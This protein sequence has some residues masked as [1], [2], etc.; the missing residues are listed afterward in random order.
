MGALACAA[1][2]GLVPAAPPPAPRLRVGIIGHTGRGDYGHGLHTLWLQLPETEI[3]AVADPDAAGL[4]AALSKLRCDRGFADY[5]KMLS[6]VR[7]D[8]V[9]IG[10]RHIDQHRDAALAAAEA[11]VRGLYIE[12]PFCR[13][14]AEADEIVAA[15]D[16]H[17]VKVAIA[18]RNRYHP[19]L[20]TIRRLLDDGAVGR[21]LEIRARGKE[22]ARGGPLDLWVL[23]SH[24]LNIVHCLGGRPRACTAMVYQDARPVTAADLKPGAEGVGPIAGNRLHARF[25]I[26]SGAPAFFDSVQNAGSAAAG[27]G[28]QWIGTQ[29]II[30]LRMDQEPMAHFRPGNPFQPVKA[31]SAWTPISSAGIGLPEPNPDLVQDVMAHRVPARDLIDAICRDREPLCSASDGRVVIEMITA[32]FASHQLRGAR[33]EWPL[34]DRFHPWAPPA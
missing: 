28:L 15:C 3:A 17:R 29:G 8:I 5:R 4:K 30:D 20:P 12:K 7:L 6:D 24:V 27:F 9:A 25:E 14:A 33:V 23:G 31:P 19:V 16:R 2:S 34:K 13:S 21:L 22:D 26:E 18:H 11:G 32:V 1:G 10:M